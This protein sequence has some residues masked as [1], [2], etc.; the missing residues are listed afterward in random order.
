MWNRCKT[1]V[2]IFDW[3]HDILPLLVKKKI[4]DNTTTTCQKSI[5]FRH[6]RTYPTMQ[7]QANNNETRWSGTGM[8]ARKTNPS[9]CPPSYAEVNHT[10]II[11]DADDSSGGSYLYGV[12]NDT[13]GCY[14]W[15]VETCQI[16]TTYTI[17]PIRNYN[18]AN[19][20]LY[21]MVYIQSTQELLMGG[22]DGQLQIWDIKADQCRDVL[23]FDQMIVG[24][25]AKNSSINSRISNSFVLPHQ[26]HAN[27]DPNRGRTSTIGIGNHQPN[28]AS[29]SS[30]S[31]LYIS[32]CTVWNE[33]WWIIGG[34]LH[35][36]NSIV[37]GYIAIIHG[38]T[39]SL[40]SFI[41]TQ[42]KIQQLLLHQSST[43]SDPNASEHTRLIA[44][45][46]SRYTYS[47][48]NPLALTDTKVTPQKV[49][50]HT[51]SAYAI[52]AINHTNTIAV[53][54]VGSVID[55]YK[56]GSH[57]CMNLSTNYR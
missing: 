20:T 33:Q 27:K 43:I 8:T 49:W 10:I 48:T 54:G 22:E 57:L 17:P 38:T 16:V 39:R 42:Y 53:G 37:S 4:N 44:L 40:L 29:P 19:R 13:F 21:T 2:A 46:N 31:Q 30:P 52:S 5:P 9:M 32:A 36:Y 6:Y 11:E 50:C 25:H 1:G 3:D 34:G 47:W 12:A 15:N 14:K 7:L 23:N 18:H 56:D 45:T 41:M 55:V 51:P 24:V 26:Q 35:R 28:G